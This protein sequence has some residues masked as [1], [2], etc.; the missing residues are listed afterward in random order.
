[1]KQ[2]PA[3]FGVYT[4]TQAARICGVSNRILTLSRRWCLRDVAVITGVPHAEVKRIV[5]AHKRRVAYR[6]RVL[7]GIG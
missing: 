1:M 4:T 3:R 6:K 7:R 2:D 5:R